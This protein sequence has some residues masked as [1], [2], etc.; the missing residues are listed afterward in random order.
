MCIV[1]SKWFLVTTPE[2]HKNAVFKRT[3][4]SLEYPLRHMGGQAEASQTLATQPN[5]VIGLEGV[6]D[7][8]HPLVCQR[9]DLGGQVGQ[10]SSFRR[11]RRDWHIFEVARQ[12][13]TISILL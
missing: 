9:L 7:L 11:I 3:L 1:P 5:T 2:S 12:S 8:I 6:L 13:R 10:I 4:I